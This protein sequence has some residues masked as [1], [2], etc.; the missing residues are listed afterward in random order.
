MDALAPSIDRLSQR[1]LAR[2]PSADHVLALAAALLP[3]LEQLA[4]AALDT[5]FSPRLV[6]RQLAAAATLQVSVTLLH[7]VSSEK[8]WPAWEFF[9][10]WRALACQR[11][12]AWVGFRGVLLVSSL[13]GEPAGRHLAPGRADDH[14]KTCVIQRHHRRATLQV[15]LAA[16]ASLVAACQ[17]ALGSATRHG[18]ETARLARRMRDAGTYAEWRAI[19]EELD[20]IEVSARAGEASLRSESNRVGERAEDESV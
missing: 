7:R 9:G 16:F 19:A 17:R 4:L 10:C 3:R 5:V 1:A 12:T 11:H 13:L 6:L 8:E 18:R 2:L 20:R 14:K 15:G